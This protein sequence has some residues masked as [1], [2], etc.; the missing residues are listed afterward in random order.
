MGCLNCHEHE[1]KPVTNVIT[2]HIAWTCVSCHLFF[3]ASDLVEVPTFTIGFLG[4]DMP[5]GFAVSDFANL[6]YTAA[7]GALAFVGFERLAA[8]VG[9]ALFTG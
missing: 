1:I 2:H 7:F 3:V 5:A 9:S 8:L 4:L 6:V